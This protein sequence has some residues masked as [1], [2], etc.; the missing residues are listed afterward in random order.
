MTTV[1]RMKHIDI[2]RKA[3]SATDKGV[4]AVAKV[5]A[6]TAKALTPVDMGELRGSISEELISRG[7][8]RYGTN[9]EYAMYVEYGTGP[10]SVPITALEGWA[11]RNGVPVGAVWISIK[12]KGT[13]PQS[14]LRLS[15]DL[16]RHRA[17]GIYARYFKRGLYG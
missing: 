5:G 13:K 3:K 12:K 8:A 4:L 6:G 14:F 10:H 1:R 16:I 15:A 11:K 7:K 17:S 2:I 9:V